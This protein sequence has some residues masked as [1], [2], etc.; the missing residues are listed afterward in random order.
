MQKLLFAAVL[1]AFCGIAL[2]AEGA[3]GGPFLA[4]RHVAKGVKC[5]ACH[6]PDHKIKQQGDYEICV[7]CHGDYDAMIKK[8]EGRYEVNPHAQHEGA[9]P[10]TECHKGHKKS[11]NY[12]GQCHSYEYN[13]P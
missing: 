3:T 8:T 6:T 4:D 7:S 11:V 5:E 12:C 10:C 1:S 9:L 2:A 13:V